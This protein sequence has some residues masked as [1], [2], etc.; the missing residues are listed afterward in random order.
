VEPPAGLL[1][2]S[3]AFGWF[4]RSTVEAAGGY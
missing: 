3:G 4:K 1:I 2:I